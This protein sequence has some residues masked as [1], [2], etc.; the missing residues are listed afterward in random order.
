MP[1]DYDGTKEYKD[2]TWDE[3]GGKINSMSPDEKKEL[4][5]AIRFVN[6]APDPLI[7]CIALIFKMFGVSG[8]DD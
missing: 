1:F 8:N 3:F 6:S 7:G 5:E 2:M 4:S